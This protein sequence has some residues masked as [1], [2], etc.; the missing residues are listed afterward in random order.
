MTIAGDTIWHHTGHGTG[1]TEEGSG[2]G[3]VASH[4]Q[5]HVHQMGVAVDGTIQAEGAKRL[6]QTL[7]NRRV[8]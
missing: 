7:G 6:C 8:R 5:P 4:T 2:G 3:Q 1:R